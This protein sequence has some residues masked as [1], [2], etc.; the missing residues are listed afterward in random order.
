MEWAPISVELRTCLATAN[1]RW[2]SWCK[3]G[4]QG[5]SFF[6][7]AHRVFQLAQDLRF[8]QHHAVEAAGH[9]E[10]VARGLVFPQHIGM[11]FEHVDAHTAGLGQP[12]QCG[13]YGG[14]IAGGIEL[15]AVA[16]G[17]QCGLGLARQTGAVAV[18]AWAEFDRAQTQTGPANQAE[19]CGG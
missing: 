9:A 8:A 6:G 13:L 17:E 1:E 5:A 4:A 12:F 18:A 7:R 19:P 16:G 2:N 10:G 14:L 15:G 3:R 11:V